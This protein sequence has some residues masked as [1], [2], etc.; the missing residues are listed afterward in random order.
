MRQWQV[1]ILVVVDEIDGL[2]GGDELARSYP[3]IV[4]EGNGDESVCV[5]RDVEFE[6]IS[7]AEVPLA[8]LLGRA[9]DPERLLELVERGRVG[10]RR[11]E[12]QAL[13]TTGE[14]LT[15]Q[16]VATVVVSLTANETARLLVRD[17]DA[18]SV[19][20]GALPRL[21]R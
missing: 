7:L 11:G 18:D 5:L 8:A 15:S 14:R 3:A 21:A 17:V 9:V 12:A 2:R 19:R 6:R 20:A 4:D 10:T 16:T 1:L 13:G